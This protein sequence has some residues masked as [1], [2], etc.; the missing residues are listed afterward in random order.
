MKTVK[1]ELAGLCDARR[2][3][4]ENINREWQSR[5]EDRIQEI[6][7]TH[8]PDGSGFDAGTTIDLDRSG[9]D[10]LVFNTSFHHMNG[11][12][13]YDGWTDHIV[14]VWPG[15]YMDRVTIAGRDRNSIKEYIADVFHQF[16][17][18]ELSP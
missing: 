15:L 10:K 6:M 5:H 3:C 9:N 7:D 17:N 16:I 11:V 4:I 2:N 8:A 18:T 13:Y 12:G 1:S 14:Y